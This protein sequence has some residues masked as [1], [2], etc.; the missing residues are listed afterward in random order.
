MTDWEIY[1][2]L[3]KHPAGGRGVRA[4]RHRA[5][6]GRETRLRRYLADIRH[7]TLSVRGDDLLAMGMKKGPAVGRILETTAGSCVW[8]G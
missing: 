7:R 3:R 1:R 5:G 2:A 4:G 6:S 8:K